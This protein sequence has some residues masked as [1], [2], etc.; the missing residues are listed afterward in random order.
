MRNPQ[1]SPVLLFREKMGAVG[2]RLPVQSNTNPMPGGSPIPGWLT[3]P[4]PACSR[5]PHTP[6]SLLIGS[7]RFYF[8]KRI[9][10][11]SN[12]VSGGGGVTQR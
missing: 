8:T 12:K 1:T 4:L 7:Q 2:S 5:H 11:G 9:R 6:S 3:T 10:E